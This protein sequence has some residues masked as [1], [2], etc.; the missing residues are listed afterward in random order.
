METYK[1]KLTVL[2]P[3]HI[4]TGEDYEPTNFVVD[5]GYLYEFD[6]VKFFGKLNAEK[7]K[8]FLKAVE[9]KAS[10]SLF[11]LHRVIKNNKEQAIESAISKVQ[12]SKGLE[13][14]Y[15]DKVGRVVQN[16]GGRRAQKSKVFNRFQI[17]RTARLANSKRV[18]I[19]GSSI[20]GAVS[21]AYQEAIFKED[22][23]AYKKLFIDSKP[24]D[25]IMKN[26]MI[27]DTQPITTYAIAGYSLNKERFEDDELGP[28]NKVE[29]IYSGSEFEVKLQIG[30]YE[31]PKQVDFKAIQASCNAHYLPLF[32]QMF[33]PKA[34]FQ[35]QKVEDYS[36]EY[37]SDN[38]YEKYKN[39]KPK[40]NQFL[41]R[42]GK[43]SGAR[44]V[45]IDGQR[46]IRV[47]VSGGGPRR[48]SN[49]WET[50]DQETTTW[51]FGGS[52]RAT[53]NLIP[54]GWVLCEVM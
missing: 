7:Q 32:E 40:E 8:E 16:E 1:L 42:V 12:V 9:S 19:P 20:K 25:I 3:I 26:L 48:K 28:S 50:L 41:L 22:Y 11:E 33:K 2:T 13:K 24:Q 43:H 36:N 46:E 10:D 35:G 39:F 47:K 53:K 17:A 34:I 51:M 45:T 21:T 30:E 18:Y 29:T 52:E 27:S 4:G 37:Y 6:E 31:V 54:F 14:D 23:K 38:F 44:A 49:K 15:E 5:N